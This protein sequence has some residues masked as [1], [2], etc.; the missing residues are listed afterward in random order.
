MATSARV[1]LEN[2][3]RVQVEATGAGFILLPDWPAKATYY[4]RDG[5]ALPNLPADPM[6]MQC[7]LARGFTL[8]PPANPVVQAVPERFVCLTCGRDD[9][10]AHIGLVSHMR[11]HKKEN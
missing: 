8:T 2:E 9:F 11:T 10:K 3:L 5:R 7:Y 6:S 1:R 4:T